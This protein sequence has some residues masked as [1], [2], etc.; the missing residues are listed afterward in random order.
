MSF[1]RTDMDRIDNDIK[2]ER[3]LTRKVFNRFNISQNK[4]PVRNN[5]L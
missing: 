4:Q 1:Q 3:R 5:K 2:Q